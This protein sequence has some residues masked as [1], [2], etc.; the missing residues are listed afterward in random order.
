M[1]AVQPTG[2]RC[3]WLLHCSYQSSIWIIH[4]C[5]IKRYFEIL[6]RTIEIFNL[7][8]TYFSR[9]NS[10]WWTVMDVAPSIISSKNESSSNQ[11][12]TTNSNIFTIFPYWV[13]ISD[14]GRTDKIPSVKNTPPCGWPFKMLQIKRHNFQNK[15]FFWLLKRGL[16]ATDWQ[17]RP[18]RV[19]QSGSGTA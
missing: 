17:P 13:Q 8:K 9:V 10:I 15:N 4:W 1:Y 18:A 16:D 6:G 7:L 2:F 5:K 12:L 14:H 11:T 3:N 19:R